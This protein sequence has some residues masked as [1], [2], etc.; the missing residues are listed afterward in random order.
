VRLLRFGRAGT[1]FLEPGDDIFPPQS[2]SGV[3]RSPLCV[4]GNPIEIGPRANSDTFRGVRQ[5]KVWTQSL[6]LINDAVEAGRM[7][8]GSIA[9]KPLRPD[10]V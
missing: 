1:F 7:A 6:N 8:L 10:E 5:P 9:S 2:V 4:V 3:H